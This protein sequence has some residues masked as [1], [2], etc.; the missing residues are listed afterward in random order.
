VQLSGRTENTVSIQLKRSMKK[1]AGSSAYYHA[2]GK[3][4]VSGLLALATAK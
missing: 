4:E 1:K 2:G 3:H